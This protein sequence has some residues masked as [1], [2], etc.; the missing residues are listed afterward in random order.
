MSK[1]DG[2]NVDSFKAMS[3]DVGRIPAFKFL[4][5]TACMNLRE[6][7]ILA[8]LDGFEHLFGNIEGTED[9]TEFL[10]NL[11]PFIRELG[12]ANWARDIITDLGLAK[13]HR[14]ER[15]SSL[16]NLLKRIEEQGQ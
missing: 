6:R 1:R 14:K 3:I 13:A 10:G 8:V 4:R 7:K 11:K 15:L 9:F 2:F 5:N 12:L 16:Q